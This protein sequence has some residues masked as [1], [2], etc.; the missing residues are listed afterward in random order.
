[1]DN[2]LFDNPET[3]FEEQI[4]ELF[5]EAA[6]DDSNVILEALTIILYQNQKNTDLVELY[7]LIG[8]DGFVKVISLFEDRTVKFPS[9]GEVKE[10]LILALCY[11]YR[12]IKGLSWPEIRAK[13]PFE[14]SP[15]SYGI[16]IKSLNRFVRKKLEQ[17]FGEENGEEE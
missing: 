7:K 6:D 16:R 2:S 17:L 15:H 5:S 4:N 14:I 13:L 12:E 1:M 8:I 10:S 11:Y 3:V 9:S